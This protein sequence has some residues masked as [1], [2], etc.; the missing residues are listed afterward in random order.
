[1]KIALIGYGKM[2][3]EIE[4][5]ALLE[6]HEVICRINQTNADIEFQKLKNADVAIEFSSPSCAYEH[7][8]KC[9]SY[10]IP[11]VCGSTG[12]NAQLE[13]AKDKCIAENQSFFYA[14][15]FS[16]GVHIFFKANERLAELMQSEANYQVNIE[17][18]H[19]LQKKDYPSGTA[20]S[21]VEGIISHSEKKNWVACLEE[22]N[23]NTDENTIQI[24]SKRKNGIPG[25]HIVKYK[26]E[27]DTIEL[28]H[29]AHNR[30]GFAIGALKA[31][32]WLMGKKGFF[33]MDDL[34][35]KK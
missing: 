18:I 12:W 21:L 25:T 26:S 4:Q 15:N 1:M 8:L 27:I 28:I 2:G 16:I 14:S 13:M 30:K 10:Q 29:T 31:A 3:K 22:K 9:F 34:I 33:G 17:E 32:S 7:I 11:V 24:L 23:E 20:I 19:H 6:G 35:Q 5:I